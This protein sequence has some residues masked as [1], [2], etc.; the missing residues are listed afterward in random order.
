MV[1]H[2]RPAVVLGM[3]AAAALLV[4]CGSPATLASPAAPA[5]AAAPD[6]AAAAPKPAPAKPGGL[7]PDPCGAAAGSPSLT[8]DGVL[9]TTNDLADVPADSVKRVGENSTFTAAPEAARWRPERFTARAFPV[10]QGAAELA[11]VQP[12]LAA[13][14]T[15]PADGLT[16]TLTWGVAPGDYIVELSLA[17]SLAESDPGCPPQL[18]SSTRRTVHVR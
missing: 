9:L 4:A 12:L 14:D 1:S 18:T 6:L 15:R 8:E 10:E 5:S 7:A 3:L 11:R 2:I 16:A 13:E 17:S